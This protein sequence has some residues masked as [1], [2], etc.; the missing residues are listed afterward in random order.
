[1]N[2]VEGTQCATAA[3]YLTDGTV[4]QNVEFHRKPYIPCPRR[5]VHVDQYLAKSL[6]VRISADHG[7]THD[8]GALDARAKE[9][10]VVGLLTADLADEATTPR[11][12]DK[13][14]GSFEPPHGLANRIPADPKTL[15]KR[16]LSDFFARPDPALHNVVAKHISKPI[17][18]TLRGHEIL[19]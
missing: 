6:D 13:Q 19:A 5:R 3:S 8:A 17:Y 9:K 11:I 10:D 16:H 4:E 18:K 1:M 12:V 15:C 14:S 2:V 7:D